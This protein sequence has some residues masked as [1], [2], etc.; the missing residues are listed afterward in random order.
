MDIAHKLKTAVG[1]LKEQGVSGVWM[2]FFGKAVRAVRRMAHWM[3]GL[4]LRTHLLRIKTSRQLRVLY[5]V[6]EVEMSGGQTV[7]YRVFNL[8]EALSGQ[9]ETTYAMLENGVYLD[10]WQVAHA[11]ILVCM[12]VFDTPQLRRLLALAKRYGKPAVFDIDDLIFL[13]QYYDGF[14]KALSVTDSFEKEMYA[15]MFAKFHEAFA[16]CDFATAS[17]PYIAERMQAE[18]RAV[19]IHNGLNHTQLAVARGLPE[20]ERGDTFRICYMSGSKSHNIDFAQA[21]PAIARILAEYPS[22]CLC[23]AGYLDE[24][25]SAQFPN[26]VSRAPYMPW[27]ELLSYCAGCDVNIAPLDTS[28]PFCHAKSELKYFEAALVGVPTVASPTDTFCKC[29]RSGENGLLAETEDEWYA[30]VRS[31]IER[32]DLRTRI[33]RAAK[34]DALAR[35]TPPSIAREA[36]EAYHTILKM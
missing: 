2:V 16:Q 28:S 26:Q 14:C 10:D 27:Q 35:Y 22:V 20:R 23:V 24:D 18:K 25:L 32:E 5:I 7:R 30:A 6:N 11:D 15:D 21:K 12:R 34:A 33:R 29:I 36:L 3:R 4:L 8:M 31:L 19:V 9:A 13:P 1:L 17:T